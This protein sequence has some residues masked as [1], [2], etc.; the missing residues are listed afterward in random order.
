MLDF[1]SH[2]AMGGLVSY[3]VNFYEMGRLSAKYVQR[4]L[5]GVKPQDFPVEGIDKIELVVNAGSIQRAVY[6]PPLPL[7]SSKNCERGKA[8]TSWPRHST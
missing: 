2:V 1:L 3:A 4:V 8:G 6:L 5:T 7:Y